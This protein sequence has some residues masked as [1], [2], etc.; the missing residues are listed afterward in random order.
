MRDKRTLSPWA[1]LPTKLEDLDWT[2]TWLKGFTI[3]DV[4]IV[5]YGCLD[6]AVVIQT[7]IYCGGYGV[8]CCCWIASSRGSDI[9]AGRIAGLI[10]VDTRNVSRV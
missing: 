6:E 8:E 10:V 3:D 4:S 7:S 1:R 9:L 2:L 5:S